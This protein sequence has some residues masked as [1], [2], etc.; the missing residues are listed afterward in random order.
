MKD[1]FVDYLRCCIPNKHWRYKESAH[2]FVKA[3]TPLAIL[4]EAARLLGLRREWFRD[5]P[6]SMP[7]YDL[8]RSKREK[9]VAIGIE[10]LD[11]GETGRI[12]RAWR[13]F[14]RQGGQVR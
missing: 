5:P 10:E 4:H 9:A 3:E 8:C 6:K 7:H 14:R 12:V 13:E 1:V 2:L 11:M